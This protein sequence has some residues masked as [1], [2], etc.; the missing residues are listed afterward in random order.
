MKTK[1]WFATL[2]IGLL[3][4]LA[5]T[6]AF[7]FILYPFVI[8][9]YGLLIGAP[10]MTVFSFLIC[11]TIILFY[12]FTKKDWLGIETLKGL[13]EFAPKAVP[14]NLFG[15]LLVTVFN[16]VGEWTA[17]FMRK[18][19]I[20]LMIILSIRFDPFITVVHIRHGAHQYN[21]LSK[22][23]WKV[24]IISLIIGNTYWALAVYMGITIVEA[25]LRL[26]GG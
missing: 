13:E 12:D 20:L 7:D 4:N 16:F 11:Y 9:K 8:V 17:W 3:G 25:I 18:S 15:R 19:D 6:W 22:R 2:G 14:K 21:G 24:F 10:I 5:I 1:K 23:D 26:I